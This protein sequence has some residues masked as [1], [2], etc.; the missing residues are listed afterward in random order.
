[1]LDAHAFALLCQEAYQVEPDYALGSFRAIF[2]L[3]PEGLVIAIRGTDDGE[4][5]V[6][7]IAAMPWPIRG[8]GAVHLGFWEASTHAYL[9]MRL[10]ARQADHVIITGHSLGGALALL[11]AAEL[12]MDGIVPEVITFGAPRV[13]IGGQMAQLFAHVSLMP[14]MYRHGCDIVPMLPPQELGWVHPA[15]LIPIGAVGHDVVREIEDHAISKYIAVLE[16][17]A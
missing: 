5:A 11:I 10:R 7:D 2:R 16:A 3:R 15:P 12:V 14:Q 13:S 8:L 9:D 6:T 17:S 1:M 4:T